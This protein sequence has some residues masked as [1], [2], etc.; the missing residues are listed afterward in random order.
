MNIA[1][2]FADPNLLHLERI[3]SES[4]RITLIVKTMPRQA[5][6]P[7]CH[8]PSAHLHSRYV[9]R[10]ADLPWLGGAVR[11]ELRT[12][13][14]YCRH[15]DCP[16][17]IFCER[18]PTF[19]APYARRTLRL[20]EALRLIGLAVGGEAG[21]QLAIALGMSVSP[22]TLI[23]RI[24]QTQLPMPPAPRVIGVDDWAKHKGQSYGTIVVDL[25]RRSTI[26]LLPD[27]EASSLANWLKRNP[28][29]ELISRDRAGTYAD[30]ARQGAPSAIQIADRW[31]LNKNMTEA[32][33]RFLNTKHSCLRQAVSKV[34]NSVADAEKPDGLDT[35]T[36]R[37]SKA[38]LWNERKRVRYEQVM[39]LYRQGASIQ[40][41]AREFRMHQRTVRTMLRADACPQRA[42]P[43][44][45]KSQ[46]DRHIAYLAQRW[47]EGCHNSAQLHRELRGQGYRGSESSVRHFVARWRAELPEGLRRSRSGE[48][49]LMPN[50]ETKKVI[51]S[52]R[53]AAWLLVRDA[54]KLKAEEKALV[55]SLVELSPEIAEAQSVAREFNRILKQRDHKS[56]TS[57]MEQT[58][59]SGIPEMKKFALGLERDRAAVAAALEYEWSNGPTEGHINRLKTLKRAMYGRAKFD[60][61]RIRTL[62]G[63]KIGDG[64]KR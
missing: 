53:R 24:R 60:L 10:L 3:S 26:D 37:P 59:K 13:R 12:R 16:Q 5:I 42:A 62:A 32:V 4:D 29:V 38:D 28:S 54:E 46:I 33:E 31:H 48:G 40:A 19:V 11:L 34:N 39:Q 17:R 61:L 36:C 23:H 9:R 49:S 51:A 6:C 43:P 25:E 8:S 20:N 21:A 27:R 41:I 56:F 47:T 1:S 35:N 63:T 45:R 30:G 18:I 64:L 22:D 57:W 55:K 58:T 44:K 7:R 50:P 15:S 52:A 14:F 2:L